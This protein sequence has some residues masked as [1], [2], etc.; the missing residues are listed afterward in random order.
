MLKLLKYLKD[1]DVTGDRAAECRGL[2][3]PIAVDTKKS[4][5]RIFQVS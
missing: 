2:M 4:A 1:S 3:A 5:Y